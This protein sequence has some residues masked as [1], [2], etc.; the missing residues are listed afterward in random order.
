MFFDFSSGKGGDLLDFICAYYDVPMSKAIG[1]LKKD[2][3]VTDKLVMSEKLS[4][5]KVAK[6]YR[7]RKNKEKECVAKKMPENYMDRFE[8]DESK[9]QAWVDEGISTEVLQKFGVRYDSFSDRLVYPIRDYNGDIV[10]VGG[11]TLD[12]DYKEKKIRKY[13]YYQSWGT[14]K[15]LGGLYDNLDAI[16]NKHEVI[17]FEGIKSVML[18]NTWGIENSACVFTS[19]LNK[20][21]AKILMKLGCNV[22]F[23]FDKDV[24]ITKDKTAQKL[25]HYCKVSYIKDINGLIDD[26]DAP[27]DKG[28]DVF[29]KLY[30]GRRRL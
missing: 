8:L 13:T 24:D 4:A 30:E 7:E 18:A 22:V 23:A 1:I 15:V 11:R 20:E 27:V 16:K 21:Q 26:K 9:L 25:K 14:M 10:N 3:G 5:V 19:H 12:P 17:L 29:L 6:R 2:A 28:K